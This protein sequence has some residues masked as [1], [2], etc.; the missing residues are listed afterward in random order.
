[1]LGLF[2]VCAVVTMGAN[3]SWKHKPIRE[4][5][6]EDALQMLIISPW[7]KT[8][9]AA[10]SRLLPGNERRDGGRMGGTTASVTTGLTEI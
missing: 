3:P 6:E 9:N 8:A 5:T 7:A 1:M 4:W 10:I 2:S